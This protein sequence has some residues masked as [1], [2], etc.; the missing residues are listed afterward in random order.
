MIISKPHLQN[1]VKKPTKLMIKKSQVGKKATK[2]LLRNLK[3]HSPVMFQL[4]LVKNQNLPKM[5]TKPQET[6]LVNA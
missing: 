3:E 1:V 6:L 4:T 2:V 5:I